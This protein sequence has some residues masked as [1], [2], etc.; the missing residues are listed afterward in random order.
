MTRIMRPMSCTGGVR[1]RTH[2]CSYER[3]SSYLVAILRAWVSIMG[4]LN[5][6]AAHL[7]QAQ[8][9]QNIHAC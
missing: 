8:H 3:N 2:G 7:D 4:L 9:T 5:P 6:V 1:M